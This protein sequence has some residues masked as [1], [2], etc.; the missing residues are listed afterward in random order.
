MIKGRNTR[1][2]DDERVNEEQV[3]ING[4]IGNDKDKTL[5]IKESMREMNNSS[6]SP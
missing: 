5:G 3:L 6:M 1:E 4:S 2:G